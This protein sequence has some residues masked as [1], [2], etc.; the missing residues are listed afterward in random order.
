M[1]EKPIKQTPVDLYVMVPTVKR[2]SEEKSETTFTLLK[3]DKIKEFEGILPTKEILE[4]HFLAQRTKM[5]IAKRDGEDYVPQPLYL[6]IESGIFAQLVKHIE[7]KVPRGKKRFMYE[8]TSDTCI[9]L[10]LGTN[11]PCCVMSPQ[12]EVCKEP[13]KDKEE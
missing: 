7:A 10:T 5:A 3:C 13:L 8:E 12:K 1:E 2:Y 4:T 9:C 11:M 6:E